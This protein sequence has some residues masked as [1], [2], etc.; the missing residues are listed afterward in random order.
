MQQPIT[1]NAAAYDIYQNVSAREIA[2]GYLDRGLSPVPVDFMKKAPVVKG[3]TEKGFRHDDLARLF[4]KPRMNIGIVLGSK[5]GD[6]IDID[7]DDDVAL[8]LAPH[9]L[10]PTE[11]IFG[12]QSRPRSHYIF[13]SDGS[14]YKKYVRPDAEDTK[15]ST[16][17]EL[18]GEAN[19]QSVFPGSVHESGERVRFDVD[20][21]PAFVAYEA[22][23]LACLRIAVATMLRRNWRSGQRHDLALAAAGLLAKAGWR[24]DD[25]VRLVSVV[26]AD[27]ADS[28]IGD[29]IKAVRD[30]YA[31]R[32]AGQSINGHQQLV[33]LL[34][35][36]VADKLQAWVSTGEDAPL[37]PAAAQETDAP[38]DVS[39]DFRAAESFAAAYE[40]NLIYGEG[41][42]FRRHNQV[43]R[44]ICDIKAQGV[45]MGFVREVS[46]EI[47]SRSPMAVR[48]QFE[49]HARITGLV[50]L[51]RSL[52]RVDGKD[53]DRA[54]DV[55][56]LAD[57][58][59]F[60][61]EA[62]TPS[63]TNTE[64]VT[65]C[66]GTTYDP[67]ATC[68]TWDRFLDRIFAGDRDVISFVQRAVG[69]TLSGKIGDH[70]LF[71]LI[72][73]G[74][75][76]KST[77]ITALNNLFDDYAATIPM[78]SLMQRKNGNEQTNDIAMLPGKRFVSASEG[79]AGQKLAESRV[80]RLTGGDRVA[81][82]PLYKEFIQFDPQFKLWLATNTF[83]SVTGWD[84][85]IWRRIKVIEFPVTIPEAERDHDLNNRLRAELP[86]IL[87]WGLQGYRDWKI[88]KLRAP[89]SIESVIKRY[90]SDNDT[91]EQFIDDCC[92]RHPRLKTPTK[93]LFDAYRIWCENHGNPPLAINMFGKA[94]SSKNFEKKGGAKFNSWI[95][96]GLRAQPE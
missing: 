47:S 70:C 86:G 77:F 71:V 93:T 69:Y 14:G 17:V 78:H 30:T 7:V 62:M 68:P 66:L 34:G 92:D 27:A 80:K 94:L 28:E 29:R 4:D 45:A 67:A 54:R 73:S 49:S 43:Y 23:D 42:W 20:G 32:D 64:I 85:S 76:G 63:T 65:K 18:R 88:H 19:K 48:T 22:L 55:F 56:G 59:V 58:T 16:I 26:A 75:N 60:D 52:L 57:G 87:N 24:L 36:K 95:G 53:I 90:R 83:P 8:A 13:Q 39:T 41:Q 33:S 91:V 50:K 15:N 79:E 6:L 12:R 5:S 1:A 44:P 25:A 21:D 40:G 96:L 74:A 3:W 38:V 10:P 51:S 2:Q 11:M 35:V 61:M 9:F 46:R 81:A 72:G 82:R 84:N 31:R 37:P 89:Q